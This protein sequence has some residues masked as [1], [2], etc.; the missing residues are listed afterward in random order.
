MKVQLISMLFALTVATAYAGPPQPSNERGEVE[1]VKQVAQ[2]MGDAMVAVN[3]EKLNEIFAD[4]WVAAGASGKV[5]TKES[6][7]QSI[8]SGSYKLRSFELGPTDVQVF[9]NVAISQGSVIES[10]SRDGKDLSGTYVWMDVLKK[11]AGKWVVV[12]SAGAKVN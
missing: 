10:K 4:D 11:R 3:L 9:G 12:Q 6:M 5:L 1:A 7:L 2:D 8:K